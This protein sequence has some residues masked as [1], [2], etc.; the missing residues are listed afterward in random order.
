MHLGEGDEWRNTVVGKLLDQHVVIN[1]QNVN[2]EEAL[3]FKLDY[4]V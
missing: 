2:T 1:M 4:L 3:K